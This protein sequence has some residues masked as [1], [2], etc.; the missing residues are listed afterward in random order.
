ML[1]ILLAAALI[2]AC[3]GSVTPVNPFPGEDW[4]TGFIDVDGNQLFYYLFRCRNATQPRSL[5]LWFQGGPGYSNTFSVFAEGGPFVVNNRTGKIERNPHAWNE[6]TDTLFIDQPAPTNFSRSPDPAKI[7]RNESCVTRDL[8]V[9]LNKFFYRYGEYRGR[10]MYI[11]G[12]SYGGHYVPALA[13][14]LVR[15]GDPSFNVK[16]IAVGNGLIEEYSQLWSF[17]ETLYA[18]GLISTF[19]YLYYSTLVTLCGVA[20]QLRIKS[21]DISCTQSLFYMFTELH[22]PQDPYDLTEKAPNYTYEL[23]EGPLVEYVNRP[24]VQAA[25]GVNGTFSADNQEVYEVMK[26]DFRLS[27][28]PNIAFLLARGIK[29]FLFFGEYDYIC[30][31]RGGAKVAERIEWE[32]KEGYAKAEFKDWTMDSVLHGKYKNFGGL[33]Y[34]VVNCAGHTIFFK[35]RKFALE[36]LKALMDPNF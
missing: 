29:V 23:Y 1:V 19:K 31:M 21:L 28:S 9:F 25:L 5:T 3:R 8:H 17:P 12:V 4:N 33:Y 30:N 7:C 6:V 2:F 10:P 32:G 26:P 22:I 20:E 11:A 18:F 14:Y 34:I 24:E 15:T 35:Q 36:L 13:S 27:L 16:G